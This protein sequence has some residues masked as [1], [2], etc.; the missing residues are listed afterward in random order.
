MDPVDAARV[1]GRPI[2]LLSGRY[3][4]VV[5]VDQAAGAFGVETF[6]GDLPLGIRML[7]FDQ[8]ER[9]RPGCDALIEVAA[10]AG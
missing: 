10:P 5:L 1:E 8:V 9:L 4:R 7:A 3:G 6:H 2:R